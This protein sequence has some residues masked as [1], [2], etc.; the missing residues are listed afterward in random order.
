MQV[1]LVAGGSP[2]NWPQ[3]LKKSYDCYIGVDRGSWNLLQHDF[4]LDL[5]IGDFDSL[6]IKEKEVIRKEATHFIQAPA[7][8]DDTDTQLG[9]KK[10]IELYPKA[11]ITIIG[12]TG[13]RLDHL[14]ANLWLPL[15]PR[16]KPYAQNLIIWD[17]QNYVTYYLPGEHD[18]TKIP[19]MSYLAY[20]C[21]TPVKELT[22]KNSKYELETT[23]VL[24]ATSYA[25]NEFISNTATFSFTS[26]MVSV[27]QSKD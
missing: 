24:Q 16:F 22:I 11:T 18:I 26:G 4:P 3:E 21:L 7:E 9:L 15:E 6:S 25:S 12:A 10:A 19:E 8:K 13:G 1:L 5:A 2:E 23:D 14:L 17:N 20:C 27:I